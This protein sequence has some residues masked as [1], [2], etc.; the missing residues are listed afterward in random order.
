ML[1]KFSGFKNNGV[2]NLGYY[3]TRNCVLYTCIVLSAQQSYDGRCGQNGRYKENMHIT[4]WKPVDNVQ[5]D[6]QEIHGTITLI[7]T[8][9]IFEDDRCMEPALM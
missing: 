5:F 7:R 4:G 6:H 9:G 1:R 3:E 2:G 8:Y